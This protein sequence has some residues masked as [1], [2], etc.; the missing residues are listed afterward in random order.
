MGRAAGIVS[1]KPEKCARAGSPLCEVYM[2][3][4][5]LA[6]K[7][8]ETQ[9][10]RKEL[11]AAQAELNRAQGKLNNQ[12]FVGKAPKELIDAERAK[13]AKYSELIEKIKNSVKELE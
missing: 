10:L 8:A 11:E 1:A 13:A 9:R 5:D 4:L 3:L 6:D 12:G 2:P 7:S